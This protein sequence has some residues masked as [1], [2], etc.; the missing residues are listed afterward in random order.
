MPTVVDLK[1][2][3]NPK[4]EIHHNARQQREGQ[5]SRPKAIVDPR[6][7]SLSNTRR[8]PVESDQ[9]VDHRRHSDE[10]EQTRR[11]ATDAVPEVQQT[12]S[13]SA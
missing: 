13:Q 4:C 5:N 3:L 1:T 2:L 6:L 10:G 7:P 8:S 11:D 12:N 9:G